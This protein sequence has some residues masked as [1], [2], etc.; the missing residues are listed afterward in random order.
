MRIMEI[1]RVMIETIKI[2]NVNKSF[3][4][5]YPIGNAPFRGQDLTAYRC[6]LPL[7]VLKAPTLFYTISVYLSIKINIFA[8]RVSL[9]FLFLRYSFFMPLGCTLL[10]DFKTMPIG[11]V[12]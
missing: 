1:A 5:M 11:L 2:P 9:N 7:R 3:T 8:F 12:S 6:R 10:G 4:V